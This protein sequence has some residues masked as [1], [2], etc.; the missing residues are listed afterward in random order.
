MPTP[1]R[2][3]PVFETVT[4][5]TEEPELDRAE[6]EALEMERAAAA[7]AAEAAAAAAAQAQAEAEARAE[8]EDQAR[9]KA[10][11]QAAAEAEERARQLAAATCVQAGVRRLQDP[12]EAATTPLET[13]V[14]PDE[15]ARRE[16]RAQRFGTGGRGGRG[17]R[18]GTTVASA[19][20]QD[21]A[22]DQTSGAPRPLDPSEEAENP[23]TGPVATSPGRWLDPTR[24]APPDLPALLQRLYD[25][26]VPPVD[27][28]SRDEAVRVRLERCLRGRWP[29]VSVG[30][31][32]SAGSGLRVGASSDVDL[33][34][35]FPQVRARARAS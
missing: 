5:D 27:L 18:S 16:R 3:S 29:D 21:S 20:D 10:Q 22:A 34:A 35:F 23:Y 14:D 9:R 4:S 30:I 13:W 7:A 2:H 28:T 32:G 8:A 19:A 24:P 17:G 25:G 26:L 6:A 31:Y 15:E 33:C 11:A 1:P 12:A